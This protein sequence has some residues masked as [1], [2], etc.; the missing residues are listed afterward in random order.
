MGKLPE[1][2]LLIKNPVSLGKLV[3]FIQF[4]SSRASHVLCVNDSVIV[5]LTAR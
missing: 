3:Q 1:L 2:R 4:G 5:G